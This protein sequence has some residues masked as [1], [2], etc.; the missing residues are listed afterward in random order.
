ME[1]LSLKL[2]IFFSLILVVYLVVF[3]FIILNNFPAGKSYQKELY[4]T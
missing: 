1:I 4:D 2:V 3:A